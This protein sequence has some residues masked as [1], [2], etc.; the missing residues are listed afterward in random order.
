[1]KKA[2]FIIFVCS[3][4]VGCSTTK[5]SS[6]TKVS[7]LQVWLSPYTDKEGNKHTAQ[8]VEVPLDEK[9]TRV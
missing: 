4:I 7:N 8:I 6:S 1:M 2:F 5:P 9:V 3:V